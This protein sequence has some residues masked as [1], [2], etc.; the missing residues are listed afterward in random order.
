VPAL[1]AGAAVASAGRSWFVDLLGDGAYPHRSPD[2][3]LFN[4][5]VFELELARGVPFDER[6]TRASD[7]GWLTAVIR[8]GGAGV[9]ALAGTIHTLWLCHDGNLSNPRARLPLCFPMA[10]V[11]QSVGLEAWR[12]TDAALAALR[13]RLAGATY[14]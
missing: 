14:A 1:T 10:L 12:G 2:G 3:I 6:M 5:A 13:T 9:R 8:R 4:A 11:E 7:T